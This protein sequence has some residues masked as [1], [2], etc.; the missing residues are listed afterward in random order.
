MTSAN[1]QD[2]GICLW[3]VYTTQ[4]WKEHCLSHLRGRLGWLVSAHLR[5]WY[6]AE[7]SVHLPHL[8]LIAVPVWPATVTWDRAKELKLNLLKCDTFC[9]YKKNYPLHFCLV[10]VFFHSLS[11]HFL[12]LFRHFFP[13]H[14]NTLCGLGCYLHNSLD[15]FSGCKFNLHNSL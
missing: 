6:L 15:F 8:L 5:H 1:F 7:F 4:L 10:L 3:Q 11:S 13:L 9:F 2:I 14:S 12:R